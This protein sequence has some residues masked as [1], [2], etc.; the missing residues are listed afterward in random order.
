VGDSS[1]SYS[2]VGLTRTRDGQAE[3]SEEE[4]HM[5]APSVDWQV[6]EDTL[7]NFNLYY[8]KDPAMG[9]YTTLP[10]SGLFLPNPNGELPQDAFSGDANWN[11]FEKEVLL[12]GYK[13]NHNIN[14]NWN[15]LQNFRYTDA[16]A[17]Q[18]NTYGTGLAADG[19]TL[20]RQAYLTD[21]TTTGFTVDNQFSGRFQTG[22]ARHNILV[23]LD[24]LS[25]DSDVIYEDTAAPAID[26][27]DPDYYQITQDNINIE[28][29]AL[30]SDFNIRKK[31]LGIYFQDQ[32]ELNRFVIIGGVRW[33]DF[34]GEEKGRQYGGT[35]DRK[36]DQDNVST[37]AGVMYRGANGL[38]P[39]INYAESFEPQTGSDRN[40]NEFDPSTGDQWELGL[41]Y[42][43]QDQQTSA[44]LAFYQI[45]KDN[46]PT[47]D[48][49][50]GPYDQIQAGEV[51]SQGIELEARAQPIDS[52]LVTASY[53]LQDVEV[54]KDNTGLKGQTPVWVPEH[55]LSVW[56][57]YGF[58]DGPLNGLVAG[59][60]ARYI[61]EAEYD[62]ATNEGKVPDTTLVDIALR[63]SLGRVSHTL[64]GTELGLSVN[65]LTDER[66]YSCFDSSN[67][68]FGEERT[69]E[70]SVSYRF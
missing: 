63:Y 33:D 48:P 53:T 27:F 26:L 52:L 9:I 70:A 12:A 11:E 29:T 3:T 45:T 2:L 50:G 60:G 1:L 68:W 59:I 25:L 47:R 4:R 49:N 28:N 64:R 17:F 58:Y 13:V 66:Y 67:C 35:V 51:R 32:I 55:L 38:S 19:R 43:S 5:I 54:T 24:Y 34:T 21:E 7:I 31:Q 23:G 62:A 42:Q 40:G 30:S 69:V 65:N 15:F 41:K 37:R 46:V 22:S 10:A 14:D 36:L 18:T 39:Y 57:D 56:A 20:S 16:E 44:N 61:G 6:S 8:Q